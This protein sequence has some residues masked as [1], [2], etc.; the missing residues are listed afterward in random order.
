MIRSRL[1]GTFLAAAIMVS[2]PVGAAAQDQPVT[3]EGV[4]WALTAYLGGDDDLV[5]VPFGVDASLR[6][7]DGLASGSGGCNTFD[8]SYQIDGSALV[9]SDELSRTLALCEDD[10]QSVEDSY[11]AW[12]PDV[13][14]WAIAN[15]V[16]ELSD[17]FGDVLLTFELRD[18][19][20]TPSEM[21]A[22]MMT[23]TEMQAE[24]DLQRERLDNVN[25]V[26][27]RERIKTLEADNAKL[28]KQIAAAP[29]A[30]PR[31]QPTSFNKAERVLL[32][33]VPQRIASRCAP[34][35]DLLYAGA[36]AAV[37]CTPNTTAVASMQYY[38]MD[39]PDAASAFGDS[40]RLSNVPEST[41]PSNTCGNSK[42]SWRA[43]IGNGWQSEGCYRDPGPIAHV[44]FVDNAT[45]CRVLNVSGQRLRSP[46]L[47]INLQDSNGDMARV[48]QWATKS[49]PGSTGQITSV[50]QPIKR[51]GANISP[52]C[53]T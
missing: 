53:P 42:K 48:Y 10:I 43:L 37:T 50:T 15:G 39:G 9:F 30:T 25:I 22:L 16:L 36:V 5:S 23:L 19:A 18:L 47:Y 13:A 8:G 40:M 24:I 20:W 26:R 11:L 3:P 4:D 12:L 41:G 34:M 14:G 6:L 49:V 28:K 31:P 51:P 38:L 33:G 35:R 1:F 27:L 45:D 52:S 21:A 46:A 32:E 7:E 2:F 17:G 44:H 29:K